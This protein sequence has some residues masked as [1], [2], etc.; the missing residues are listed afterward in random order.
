MDGIDVVLQSLLLL[1]ETIS[2]QL[3]WIN[4]STP[5]YAIVSP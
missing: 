4:A 1:P 3:T 5:C 2:R